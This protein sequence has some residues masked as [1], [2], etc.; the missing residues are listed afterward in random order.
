MRSLKTAKEREAFRMQHHEEMQKRAQERGMTLPDEPNQN[1]SGSGADVQQ[2]TE[3][4]QRNQQLD[5][6]IQQ[7]ERTRQQEQQQQQQQ[8]Q[9]Q[10]SQGQ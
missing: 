10:S 5:Q 2:R 6:Q 1:R 9:D 7:Q 8:Q 3:Q 4:Q